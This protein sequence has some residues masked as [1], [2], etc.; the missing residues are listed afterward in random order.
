MHPSANTEISKKHFSKEFLL[1][2][3][4]VCLELSVEDDI[5]GVSES[6]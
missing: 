4:I 3:T 1:S 6:R 2:L 5:T